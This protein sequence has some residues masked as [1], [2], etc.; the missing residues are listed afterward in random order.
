[1]RSYRLAIFIA[2]LFLVGATYFQTPDAGDRDDDQVPYE[3]RHGY[4]TLEID[5]TIRRGVPVQAILVIHARE[6]DIEFDSLQ[7]VTPEEF[8][9]TPRRPT[10]FP[11]A[12]GTNERF[13]YEAEAPLE[14]LGKLL[15]RGEAA[16]DQR[17][18]VR[19]KIDIFLSAPDKPF[20][21]SIDPEIALRPFRPSLTEVA[22]WALGGLLLGFG[23]KRWTI[24]RSNTADQA[25]QRASPERRWRRRFDMFRPV[26]ADFV[27]TTIL[28]ILALL[29]LLMGPNDFTSYGGAML[30]GVGVGGLGDDHLPRRVFS[31][32]QL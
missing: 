19:P 30:A 7:N 32:G 26:M 21:D 8:R 23:L 18:T 1:M 5:G 27:F 13:V 9:F 22:L 25:E 15:G 11:V 24:W 28:G 14:W 6:V 10:S 2:A 17:P 20:R 3:S 16:P 31:A 4:V 12:A 29:M